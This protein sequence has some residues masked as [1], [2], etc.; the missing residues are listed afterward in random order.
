ML[1]M[2]TLF[3]ICFVWLHEWNLLLRPC[4]YSKCLLPTTKANTPDVFSICRDKFGLVIWN[5]V[6][7]MR[8]IFL[9]RFLFFNTLI[10][11]SY[12]KLISFCNIP[13]IFSHFHCFQNL[14][15]KNFEGRVYNK[16]I[17]LKT[18]TINLKEYT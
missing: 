11:L 9:Q 15:T 10:C 7:N 12:L 17:C 4:W 16:I 2:I 1:R 8:K 6:L 3:N 14:K 13:M 18:S 5:P